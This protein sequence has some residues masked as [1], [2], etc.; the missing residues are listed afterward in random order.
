MNYTHLSQSERYQIYA[1]MKAGQPLSDIAKILHRH[2]S[3]IYREVSRNSCNDPAE[4]AQV[5]RLIY[6]LLLAFS[7]P[8][9]DA[10]SDC[11]KS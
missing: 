6:M 10:V 4:S 7:C 9:P 3:T 5:M 11:C 8:A 2:R 1:L